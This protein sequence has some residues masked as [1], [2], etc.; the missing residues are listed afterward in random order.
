VIWPVLRS[1][2]LTLLLA[3]ST[4]AQEGGGEQTDSWL[5]WKW[6]NFAILALGLGYLI[7]KNVPELFRKRSEEIQRA[8]VEA[9]K[10]HKDAEARAFSIQQRLAALQNEI[11]GMRKTAQTEMASEGER[12]SRETANRVQKI[13]QQA[14]EEI[15]LMSRGIRDELRKYSAGIALNLAEGRIRQRLNKEIEDGLVDGFLQDLRQRFASGG[16]N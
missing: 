11:E 15:Q 16:R 13:Q 9:T 3:A 6:A 7:A 12:I 8:I 1:A 5:G 10:A 14:T 4:F 2:G